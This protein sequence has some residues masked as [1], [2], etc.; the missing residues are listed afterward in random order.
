MPFAARSTVATLSA[1]VGR[2]M[3]V[4]ADL[5][6]L[7]SVLE[8]AGRPDPADRSSASELGRS[9]VRAAEKL[10]RPSPIPILVTSRFDEDPSQLRR[11]ND[12]T[13]GL[14]RPEDEP[15]PALV[16]P[17]GH[18]GRRTRSRPTPAAPAGG[19]APRRPTSRAPSRCRR[20]RGRGRRAD[21]DRG[22]RR[23]GRGRG[24]ADR[25]RR[26]DAR[27][28]PRGAR[29]QRRARRR[30]G[31]RPPPRLPPPPAPGGPTKLYDGDEDLMRDELAALA[32]LPVDDDV[33]APAGPPT[34]D[35]RRR[36]RPR[37]PARPVRRRRSSRGRDGRGRVAAGRRRR[38][39]MPW[40]HRPR[41]G[42]RP[43]RA[44]PP[45]LQRCSRCPSTPSPSSS[46]PT[47][48]QARAE[49]AT[50]NWDIEI[51]HERSDDHPTPGEIIR[52]A[53]AAGEKLAEDEPFLVVVSDGPE[54]R[55]LPD[56]T[57][58]TQAEA[59][60]ELARAAARRRCRRCSRTT[61][62]SPS[63]R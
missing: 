31:G 36:R 16:P 42:R 41:R 21:G 60:T 48:Q 30:G 53:P 14:H 59:E 27:G 9:L 63:A 40:V 4:S 22:R 45:R 6:P 38:R 26:A 10:P 25:S 18:A 29:R 34:A 46:G 50:F 55:D 43:R 2:L 51:R 12:P 56:L 49:T 7:A 62:T 17:V 11:P 3:P 1:R 8:R 35:P 47:E 20:R 23:P 61:R 24:A 37:R 58:L 44:R 52:T 33:A 57:G 28:R 5:G 15:A 13:G 32:A 54:F 19:R 39:W